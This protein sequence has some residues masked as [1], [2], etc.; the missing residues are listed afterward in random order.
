MLAHH[1]P[2]ALLL[3]R[4]GSLLTGCMDLSSKKLVAPLIF[5]Q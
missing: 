1:L 2:P 5:T 4:I 3:Y